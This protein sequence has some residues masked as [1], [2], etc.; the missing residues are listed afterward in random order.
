MSTK[1]VD[2]VEKTKPTL[3]VHSILYGNEPDR[4]RQTVAHLERAA[5]FAISRGVFS[6]VTVVYGD[7][8]P[9]PVFTAAAVD[10]IAADCVAISGFEHRFFD[11]NL[12]SAQGHN[13][14][15]EDLEDDYVLVMNPDIMLAPN[16]LIEL[17][18]PF[19]RPKVGMVEAKQLP[20]EHPKHYDPVTGET[21]WAAT[22]CTLIPAKVIKEL[23]GFD[24]TT[25]FLYCDDVDFSWRVRLSGRTVIYQATAPVFHDKRLGKGG[26]WVPGEAEKY[27][28]AEAALMLAHKYSRPDLVEIILA[29]FRNATQPHFTKALETYERRAKEG[30]LPE[31]IDP[32]HSVAV[33]T[34]GAYSPHRF[35]M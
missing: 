14:L 20:I 5:D 10:E 1:A 31:P 8:S 2:M 30:S 34:S 24:H 29:D 32:R 35:E 17:M 26:S 15:L 13:R 6:S 11:A 22:A 7:C 23:Q 28:S 27:F 4:I 3:R 9:E 25:F 33:F 19:S 21:I 12:G 18:R 16:T